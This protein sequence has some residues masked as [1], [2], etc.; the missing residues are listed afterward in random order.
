MLES[1]RSELGI[2]GRI[3]GKCRVYPKV[4]TV[5]VRAVG[6]KTYLSPPLT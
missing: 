6:L 5:E 1:G 2:F 3:F 4:K